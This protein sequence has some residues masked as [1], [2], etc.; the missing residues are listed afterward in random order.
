MKI[1]YMANGEEPLDSSMDDPKASPNIPEMPPRERPSRP[2]RGD[3]AAIDQETDDGDGSG[4]DGSGGGSNGPTPGPYIDPIHVPGIRCVRASMDPRT[5][6]VEGLNERDPAWA[7]R[8]RNRRWTLAVTAA[9]P[10]VQIRDLAQSL[11]E[12][13]GAHVKDCEYQARHVRDDMRALRGDPPVP[14]HRRPI[15]ELGADAHE[16]MLFRTQLRLTAYEYEVLR[17]YIAAVSSRAVDLCG[18]PMWAEFDT[19]PDRVWVRGQAV[20]AS[21]REE[22]RGRLRLEWEKRAAG[23]PYETEVVVDVCATAHVDF[24]R[25]LNYLGAIGREPG[26]RVDYYGRLIGLDVDYKSLEDE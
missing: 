6:L 17:N 26:A 10:F 11:F 13:G 23:L 15:R 1:P 19:R 5:T 16:V 18:T 24:Q 21:I 22:L 20:R 9:D 8:V 12:R 2:P 14:S 25:V 3:R 7:L 4:G